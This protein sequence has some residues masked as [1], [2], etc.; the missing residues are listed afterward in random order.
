M[1][2]IFI[3]G[4]TGQVNEFLLSIAWKNSSQIII[5]GVPSSCF[6]SSFGID[7]IPKLFGNAIFVR[8][9]TSVG[10][11]LGMSQCLMYFLFAFVSSIL[12]APFSLLVLFTCQICVA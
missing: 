1:G 2:H 4:R 3:T 6:D 11:N 8:G 5:E 12:N 10:S 9:T 7:D